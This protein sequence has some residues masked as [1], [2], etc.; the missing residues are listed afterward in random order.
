MARGSRLPGPTRVSCGCGGHTGLAG[1]PEGHFSSTTVWGPRRFCPILALLGELGVGVGSSL[2][3]CGAAVGV[4]EG[5]VSLS[6]SPGGQVGVTQLVLIRCHFRHPGPGLFLES[7]PVRAGSCDCVS[8]ALAPSWRDCFEMRTLS[9][10]LLK[11]GEGQPPLPAAWPPFSRCPSA[12]LPSQA[13]VL[14]QEA[15]PQ[16]AHTSLKLSSLPLGHMWG[17][18]TFLEGLVFLTAAFPVPDT[19]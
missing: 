5:R 13:W 11:S 16:P 14:P 12:F 6:P 18:S 10:Y 1:A 8:E 3:S 9:V 7:P 17:P 4:S 15:R 19:Q 2:S